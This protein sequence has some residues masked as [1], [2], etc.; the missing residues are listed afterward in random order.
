MEGEMWVDCKQE[1]RL[2]LI[3]ISHSDRAG[4]KGSHF[5]R[6]GPEPVIQ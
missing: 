5:R 4:D 6:D 3:V 2:P 1:R